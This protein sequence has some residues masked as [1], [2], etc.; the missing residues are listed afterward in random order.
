MY[1]GEGAGAWPS[2]RLFANKGDLRGLQPK[3]KL[4]NR[5]MHVE[6]AIPTAHRAPPFPQMWHTSCYKAHLMLSKRATVVLSC[7]ASSREGGLPCTWKPEG[8]A[9]TTLGETSQYRT[10]ARP[11]HACPFSYPFFLQLHPPSMKGR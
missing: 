2:Q 9:F 3:R 4:V 6:D 1:T 10:I 5:E 7:T 11:T 8:K